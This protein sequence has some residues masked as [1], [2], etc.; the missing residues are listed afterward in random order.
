MEAVCSCQLL[1]WLAMRHRG[2]VARGNRG[3]DVIKVITSLR[4]CVSVHVRAVQFGQWNIVSANPPLLVTDFVASSH[5]V[6]VLSK[7]SF[8]SYWALIGLQ[9]CISL[10]NTEFVNLKWIQSL[11][12]SKSPHND[13]G[14]LCS[15]HQHCPHANGV[16][17]LK[18]NVLLG[19]GCRGSL[20]C[21]ALLQQVLELKY[22]E[23]TRISTVLR[24][25]A[26]RNWFSILF[27]ILKVTRG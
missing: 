24:H 27:C 26:C 12:C 8:C 4:F 11:Y 3:L 2:S 6:L 13:F 9:W 7:Y 18:W 5:N 20:P 22:S 25:T 17:M 19:K 21:S 23:P 15:L 1:W 10:W 16:A 14:R